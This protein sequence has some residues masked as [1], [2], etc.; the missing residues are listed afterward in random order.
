MVCDFFP[1]TVLFCQNKK[2]LFDKILGNRILLS[3]LT[4]KLRNATCTII[5]DQA[6]ILSLKRFT[7][8]IVRNYQQTSDNG[9]WSAELV[10]LA[11]IS[12]IS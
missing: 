3:L 9:I 2:I 7:Q 4:V 10:Q 12:L 5:F 1:S 11:D 6:R 8:R